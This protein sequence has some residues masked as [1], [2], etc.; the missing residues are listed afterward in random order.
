MI[1]SNAIVSAGAKIGNHV[2]VDPFAVVEDNVEIGD[3]CWIGSHSVI[4]S[5]SV[6][7]ANNRI[8]EHVVLGGDPQSVLY[9]GESTTLVIGDNNTIREFVTISRGTMQGHGTTTVG[10]ENDVMAYCHIAHDCI[11]TNHCTFANGTSMAGHVTV[12]DYAV[13]GGF[14]MIHQHC[15]IGTSCMTG[16]NSVLRQ[17]VPP[18][19]MVNGN[20]ASV[21][22]L[23]SRGL[24]RR[25]FNDESM[26]ALKKVFHLYFP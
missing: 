8:H 17:D 21:A 6:I 2:K 24:K 1:S 25:Q 5:H 15:R 23:N 11:I 3:N 19:V 14:T 7:G 13:L 9:K 26:A 10:N 18:Y 16:I 20:P 22:A 12:D 4:R